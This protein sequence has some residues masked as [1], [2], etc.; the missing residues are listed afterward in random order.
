[1]H[2]LSGTTGTRPRKYVKRVD[3]FWERRSRPGLS[4]R[5]IA[6]S[7]YTENKTRPHARRLSITM[8]NVKWSSIIPFCV[9]HFILLLKQP[10]V[11]NASRA[12]PRS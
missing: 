11:T 12:L 7:V 1:M 8:L 3:A 4:R 5:M 6:V 2:E 10:C 9:G